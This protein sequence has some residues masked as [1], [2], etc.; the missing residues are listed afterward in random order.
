[1]YRIIWVVVLTLGCSF[2]A[3]SNTMAQDF[4]KQKEFAKSLGTQPLTAMNQFQPETTFKDYNSKPAEQRYYQGIEVEKM[5]LTSEAA[6]TLENDVAGK[7]VVDHFG[8][9]QFEVN[10]KSDII[11]N[12]KLIEDE[13]YALT[14]GLS[15][16]KVTCDAPA[17][18]CE[19]KSHEEMCHTSRQLPNETC[20]KKRNVFV[21]SDH[22]NQRSDFEVV[23]GKKW[24]GY[25]TVNLITGA[26]SKAQG[27]H[28]SNPLKLAHPC[29]QMN[30][31]IHSV[32]NNGQSAGWVRVVGLPS[33]Q[34]NAEVTLFI[35]DKFNRVY[36]IQVALTVVVHT[37]AYVQEERWDNGCQKFEAMG[38]CHRVEER[39][40]DSTTTRVI[41]G[42]PVSR[43]CWQYDATYSCASAQTDECR[44]Q[45]DKGC[46]Q[47]SS[48]CTQMVNNACSIYEQLYS[49]QE[50]V[51]PT[52]TPCVTNLFCADGECTDH[53][54]SQ[55]DDFG[56]S[57]APLAVVGEAGREFGKTQASLFSGHPVQC[58]V[59][60]GN[61]VDCC[62]NKGWADKIHL[63]MCR[64]EDKELGKA[65]LN[66]LAH[67]VGKFCSKKVLGVCTEH[68]RTYCVFDSKIARIVQEEG[69]LRQLN[70]NALGDAEDASCAGL[71]VSELQQ[72]DMGRIDFVSPVYP[73]PFGTAIKEAGIVGDVALK[74]PN[75]E[76]TM[77][78]MKRRISERAAK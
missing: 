53:I 72:L 75:P 19:I 1:M 54:S 62:S 55:N 59:W 2:I 52:K 37:K 57:I 4:Q 8:Q 14:H 23:V 51:C 18:A 69:R 35:G 27:G 50:T 78:E 65:K 38:L 60:I 24:T 13:S 48:R 21:N 49:C 73:Y 77:D 61:L 11:K 30:A 43:D 6:K 71:S 26:M 40:T 74:N 15:N 70:P 39:C 56:T 5:D 34:N 47:L 46:L 25:I 29:E 22:L 12:A 67:Y 3:F 68:K 20:I 10:K 66:Y 31:S 41:G 42:I 76:K 17:K 16:D 63:D 28:L 7:T 36:P 44:V 33:C 32:T 45:R 9:N 64:E 58:K